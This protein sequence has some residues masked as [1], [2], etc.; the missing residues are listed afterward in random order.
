VGETDRDDISIVSLNGVAMRNSDPRVDAYIEKAAPFAQPILK[1][2][3]AVVHEAVPDVQETIKWNVP[4]FEHHGIM[5]GMAAFKT[6]CHF[7]FW[8]SQLLDKQFPALAKDGEALGQLGGIAAVKDFPS[9]SVLVKVVRAAAKLNEDGVKLPPAPR[10]DRSK[11]VR[12]PADL[13]AALRNNPDARHGY[14]SLSPS[15]KREYIEWITEAK[16]DETR[17]RRVATAVEWM[18][19]GRIRNWKYVR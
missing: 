4:S 10:D 15:H 18:A 8:K 3:R 1:H 14:E 16:R 12:A 9:R 11:A 13:L 19:E 2:I 5:A 17:K 6:Y 7:A